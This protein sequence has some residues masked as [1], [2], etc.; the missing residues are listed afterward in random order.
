M[1]LNH[2]PDRTPAPP[3]EYFLLDDN[4]PVDREQRVRLHQR[5]LETVLTRHQLERTDQTYQRP[6]LFC[7]D[8]CQPS[9]AAVVEHLFRKHFL[10]LGRP[11]NL[12]YIDE[13]IDDVR[14]KLVRLVCLFC[15]KT[16]KDRPTLKEHMRKKGHKRINPD[17]K[18][19]DKFY[20]VNYTR[21]L[22]APS[23]AMAAQETA[24]RQAQAIADAEESRVFQTP[25]DSDSDWSD[26]EEAPDGTDGTAPMRCLFCVHTERR[27]AALTEHM[28]RAHGVDLDARLS[29]LVFHKR[30]KLVNYVRHQMNE[31]T[32]VTCE[33]R[34]SDADA[35][36]EHLSTAGH[37]GLGDQKQWD[38]AIYLFP[39]FEEDPLLFCLDDAP[40]M[41][42]GSSG[43]SVGSGSALSLQLRSGCA[44][45]VNMADGIQIYAEEFRVEVNVDAEA[46]SR[47]LMVKL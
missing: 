33:T 31:L 22:P 28:R 35:L 19:Y 10:H 5:R 13:L 37:Y 26:W 40:R 44:S 25:D 23:A 32:C 15:A 6:C 1:L 41:C 8:T 9:R 3:T 42:D 29:E 14:D 2:L 36:T 24:A 46:L 45:P 17:D 7:R 4:L 27:Y 39:S 16:F 30:M 12:V 18:Q 38:Q 11:E 20:M 47:E 43:S 21:E 34:F